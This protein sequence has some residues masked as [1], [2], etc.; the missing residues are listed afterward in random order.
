MRL[1]AAECQVNLYK[2]LQRLGQGWDRELA[3]APIVATLLQLL[4][5]RSPP[6][7]ARAA[8]ALGKWEL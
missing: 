3:G 2:N 4:S 7:S 8:F 5:D 1:A 6:I